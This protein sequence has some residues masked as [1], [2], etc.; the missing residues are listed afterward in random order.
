MKTFYISCSDFYILGMHAFF[1][2]RL[3]SEHE[4]AE[5]EDS[6]AQRRKNYEQRLREAN[7]TMRNIS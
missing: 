5:R 1:K 7:V 4:L 3:R 6:R 2:C